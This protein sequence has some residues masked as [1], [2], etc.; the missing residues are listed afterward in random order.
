MAKVRI[1]A[2][3]VIL[4]ACSSLAL[5]SEAA[6]Q[7]GGHGEGAE[8]DLFN[9]S[10]ADSLWTVVAFGLLVAVLA[11]FAWRPL[12]AAVKERETHIETQI[13]EAEETR[14]NAER[15]LDAHKKQAQEILERATE[16]AVKTEK[17]IVEKAREEATLMK[18]KAQGDIEHARSAAAQQLWEQA[19]EMVLAVGTEVLGRTVTAQDNGRLIDEAVQKLR[20]KE[21]RRRK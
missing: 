11:K 6:A 8:P 9:G 5:A 1:A 16:Q 4:A 20:Q 18:Q 10:W 12:L 7:P 3:F 17:D 15:L 21:A 2:V 19:G 14:R 13:K